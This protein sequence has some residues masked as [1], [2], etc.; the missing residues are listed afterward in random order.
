MNIKR[1]SSFIDIQLFGIAF[2]VL[3]IVKQIYLF[4][5]V[6]N[7]HYDVWY[8]PFQLCSMPIYMCII[9][10][11]TS[12]NRS[13]A[14]RTTSNRNKSG[15]CNTTNNLNNTNELRTTSPLN[16]PRHQKK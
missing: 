10:S 9:L 14:T 2:L 12:P 4:F 15:D 3:E 8:V 7:K 6:F 11:M 1:D 16:N 5:I 13:K